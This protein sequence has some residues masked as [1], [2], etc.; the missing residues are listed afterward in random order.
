MK[1][2]T[3]YDNKPLRV[4]CADCKHGNFNREFGPCIYSCKCNR[5]KV[6]SGTGRMEQAN[7]RYG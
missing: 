2:N 5:E 4:Y 3:G 7:L 6:I 1:Y